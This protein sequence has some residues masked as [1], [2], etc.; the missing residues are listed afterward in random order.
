[1]ATIIQV[2]QVFGVPLALVIFFVLQDTKR[3]RRMSERLDKSEDY[4]RDT[5]SKVVADNT[6]ALRADAQASRDLA[7]ELR[8]RPCMREASAK[9][10]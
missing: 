1:M 10:T 9:G 3:E 7:R 5:L 2:A 8:V 4:I 6:D